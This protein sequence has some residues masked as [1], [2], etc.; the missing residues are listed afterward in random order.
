MVDHIALV[1]QLAEQ[2]GRDLPEVL[3]IGR[4]LADLGRGLDHDGM[5]QAVPGTQ[6]VRALRVQF[7]RYSDLDP[8][9]IPFES[10]LQD[11]GHFEAADAELLGDLDLGLALEVEAAGH[12]R[13]LHQLCGSHPHG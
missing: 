11:P 5:P 12:G 13:R 9:E 2:V 3:G 6:R 10:G 1:D 4:L 7:G 8:Y